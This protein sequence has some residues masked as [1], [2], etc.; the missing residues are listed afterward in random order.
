MNEDLMATEN[1]NFKTG[2][3]FFEKKDYVSA[4]H[5]FEKSSLD[6]LNNSCQVHLKKADCHFQLLN[7]AEAISEYSKVININPNLTPAF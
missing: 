1:E 2:C 3:D 5:F 7:Y 4:L 6:G